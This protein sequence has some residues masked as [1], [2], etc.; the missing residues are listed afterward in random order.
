MGRVGMS[1]S[2]VGKEEWRCQKNG[3]INLGEQDV[4]DLISLLRGKGA[5]N[6]LFYLNLY[7]K[8]GQASR[9]TA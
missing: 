2:I 5:H 7:V 6:D 1:R 9:R 8:T 4:F 3:L